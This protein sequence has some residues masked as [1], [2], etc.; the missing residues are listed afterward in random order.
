MLYMKDAIALYIT[1]ISWRHL[2][3]TLTKQTVSGYKLLPVGRKP[4]I[5]GRDVIVFRTYA[6]PPGNLTILPYPPGKSAWEVRRGSPDESGSSPAN[7]TC[8]KYIDNFDWFN[9][10]EYRR[11][12]WDMLGSCRKL[13]SSEDRRYL[14]VMFDDILASRVPFP[15]HVEWTP[16]TWWRGGMGWSVHAQ[17]GFQSSIDTFQL[18]EWQKGD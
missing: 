16:G 3:A 2:P 14:M 10:S 9:W 1:Q 15:V 18:S 8:L 4:V 6:C 13:K 11:G 12:V 5:D 7:D 17:V